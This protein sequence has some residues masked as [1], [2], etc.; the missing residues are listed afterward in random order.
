MRKV[1]AGLRI[2]LHTL[3]SPFSQTI[4]FFVKYPCYTNIPVYIH[5]QLPLT[6][7]L[8][9]PKTSAT[10]RQ[11]F[12]SLPFLPPMTTGKKTGREQKNQNK[13]GLPFGRTNLVSKTFAQQA[14]FS[15]SKNLILRGPKYFF[16]VPLP[17]LFF[18]LWCLSS[19][20]LIFRRVEFC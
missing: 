18:L 7:H 15:M 2:S 3:L 6:S 1:N 20:G 8:N 11:Q 13:C 14:W 19:V 4:S 12:A 17:I 5:A 16:L 9:Q 10:V